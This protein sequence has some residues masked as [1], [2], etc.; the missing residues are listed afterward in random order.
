MDARELAEW[1]AYYQL[2][3]LGEVRADMRMA[4]ICQVLANTHSSGT[5]FHES[6]F[7]FQFEPERQSVEVMKKT[8]L[9]LA[10]KEP[11]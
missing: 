7:M 5:S 9:T 3:P 8:M 1:R 11:D 6:D 4:R 10:K 2:E